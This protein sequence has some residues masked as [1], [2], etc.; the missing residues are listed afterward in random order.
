V[1]ATLIFDVGN[2]LATFTAPGV[3]S[4]LLAQTTLDHREARRYLLALQTHVVTQELVDQTCA[5][6]N[7]Q[8]FDISSYE[9][10]NGYVQDGA[11]NMLQ[12]L[13]ARGH[14]IVTL[15]NTSSLDA[16]PLPGSLQSYV[17]TV[18][19]SFEIGAVKPSPEAFNHVLRR[20]RLGSTNAIMVGDSLKADI[21]G[22]MAL[23]MRAVWLAPASHGHDTCQESPCIMIQSLRQ[24]SDVLKDEGK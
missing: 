1:K 23:G 17:K 20:E 2:T 13:T 10:P 6:L 12:E 3:V 19:R 8:T 5:K 15:S 14:P 22:A 16:S 24:L 11:E 7:T 9:T 18:Y 21:Y 4:R